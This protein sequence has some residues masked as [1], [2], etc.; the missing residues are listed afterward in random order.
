MWFANLNKVKKIK[1]RFFEVHF[2]VI[3]ENNHPRNMKYWN[4]I[5]RTRKWI[6]EHFHIPQCHTNENDVI[7]DG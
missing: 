2:C 6:N 3:D 7:K 4:E 5:L 1:K